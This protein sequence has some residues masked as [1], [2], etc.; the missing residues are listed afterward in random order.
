MD[1]K[2]LYRSR[3]DRVLGG[4]CSG[5]G[6][7]FNIDPVI[8]RLIWA[9]LFFAAGLGFLAYIIAWIVVPVEP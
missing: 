6:K 9:L 1:A 3:N 7:Y 2:R 4:V 5:L 8:V